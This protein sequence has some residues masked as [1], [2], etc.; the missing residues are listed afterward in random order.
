MTRFNNDIGNQAIVKPQANVSKREVA[1]R[2]KKWIA[3]YN[4]NVVATV[5]PDRVNK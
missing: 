1:R 3:L 2:F 5:S 4:K